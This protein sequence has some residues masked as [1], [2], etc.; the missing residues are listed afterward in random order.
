MEHNYAADDAFTRVIR[1][2]SLTLTLMNAQ[3]ISLANQDY[4]DF[5]FGSR[6]SAD[7]TP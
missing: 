7:V 3:Q 2:S 5:H 4:A 6:V 1:Y